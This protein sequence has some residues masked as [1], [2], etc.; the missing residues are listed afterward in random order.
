LLVVYDRGGQL[1]VA[2]IDASKILSVVVNAAL[3]ALAAQA[4]EMLERIIN[5]L[6][7]PGV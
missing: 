7:S 3:K 5:N 2:A 1:L 6:W 4:N